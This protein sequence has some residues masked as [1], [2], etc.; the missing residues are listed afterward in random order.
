[1]I[2]IVPYATFR[3]PAHFVDPDSFHPERF[4][5]KDHPLYDQRFA[6]DD[7][8]TLRPF[9]YGQRDCIGKNLAYAE[10][11]VIMAKFIFLYDYEL[12][13]GQDDWMDRMRCFLVW[14]KDSLNIKVTPARAV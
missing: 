8:Q 3:N 12:L 2:Q 7:L 1:M 11:R 6:N 14:E 13:P 5:P 4:L 10:M 9:S